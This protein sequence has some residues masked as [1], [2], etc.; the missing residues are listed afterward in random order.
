MN[1]KTIAFIQAV[2]VAMLFAGLSA[3]ANNIGASGLV[4]GTVATIIVGVI[5]ILENALSNNG[6]KALL[7]MV[8]VA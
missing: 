3:V 1:P 5:G 7:G 4:S 8:N 2:A 6:T